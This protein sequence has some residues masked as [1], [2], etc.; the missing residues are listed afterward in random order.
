MTTALSCLFIACLL[1]LLCTLGAKVVGSAQGPAGRFNNNNPRHWLAQ[2]TGLAARLNAAQQNSWEAL[3]IFG[4]AVVA[5]HWMG[6]PQ[7]RVD[8]LALVFVAAR[9]VYVGV[10]AADTAALRSLV[11]FAGLASSLA[12][13]FAR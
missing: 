8:L 6:A 4:P 9:V 5:A 1:P 10:Y 3:A 12:L 2:Q 7:G 11:W 13:F